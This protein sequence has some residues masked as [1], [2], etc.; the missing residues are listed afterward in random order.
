MRTVLE[1]RSEYGRPQKTLADP[2]RYVD[3]RYYDQALSRHV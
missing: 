3:T 1:L 2:Q